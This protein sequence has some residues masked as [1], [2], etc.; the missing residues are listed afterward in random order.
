M[1]STRR[2]DGDSTRSMSMENSDSE[3]PHSPDVLTV[4]SRTSDR[5]TVTASSRRTVFRNTSTN[6][7]TSSRNS[8]GVRV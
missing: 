4:G 1:V 5:P 3:R 2:E 7:S 6:S 8:R